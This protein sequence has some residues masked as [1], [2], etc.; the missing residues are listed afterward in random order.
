MARRFIWQ[1][2]NLEM[3]ELGRL[4]L[5]DA[6]W[7]IEEYHSE[8][9]QVTNVNL[10]Q[11]RKAN[12]Q[13][14]HI[15]LALRV[16]LVIKS[17]AFII[18]LYAECDTLKNLSWSYPT[19]PKYRFRDH[20]IAI[21]QIKLTSN[22]KLGV[23]MN[24][25]FLSFFNP[26]KVYTRNFQKSSTTNLEL[27]PLE[28]RIVPVNLSAFAV[29]AA[30]ENLENINALGSTV[31]F[32]N[33]AN[34]GQYGITVPFAHFT[35]ELRTAKGEFYKPNSNDPTLPFEIAPAI[36]VAAGSG[37]GPAV[38]I[39]DAQTGEIKRSFFA[40]DASFTGGVYLAAKDFNGDGIS[41]IITGAGAGGSAHIKIFDGT[42][43]QVLK[44]F[45]AFEPSFTGGVRV[46]AGD[47]N[48]DLI[49]EIIAAAGQGG[50]PHVKIFDGANNSLV[51]SWFAYEKD[52]T[53]GVYVAMGDLGHD[54]SPEVI[55]GAGI[56]GGPVVAIWNAST[57]G[58]IS[59]FFAYA[60]E[61]T[62]GVRVSTGD[63]DGNGVIDLITGAGIGGGPHIKVFSS[64]APTPAYEFFAGSHSATS[65]I[66][67]TV[68][69]ELIL[70][71]IPDIASYQSLLNLDY[72]TF[73]RSLIASVNDQNPNKQGFLSMVRGGLLDGLPADEVVPSNR[74]A[75][76]VRQ[77]RP[78]Q[79]E[80]DV[81][82]SLEF[83]L[84]NPNEI[85]NIDAALAGGTI[86]PSGPI[87]T[88]YDGTYL[89]EGH[90]RWSQTFL[91]NPAAS[92]LVYDFPNISDPFLALKVAQLGI[93]AERSSLDSASGGDPANNLLV[94]NRSTFDLDIDLMLDTQPNAKYSTPNTQ[95]QV[96]AVMA[97]FGNYNIGT[98]TDTPENRNA[99]K[100]Y[101]WKNVLV[102]QANNQP[103]TGTNAPD[104]I[105]MPQTTEGNQLYAPNFFFNL[106]SGLVNFKSP[107]SY[108]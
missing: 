13:R 106:A 104:R 9:K 67:P 21:V 28:Q 4:C 82:K 34:S 18:E 23:T 7:K 74:V 71:Q 3:D 44:S 87:I 42:T 12:A 25:W 91:L 59:R 10:C 108:Q 68:V 1:T 80:L 63:A 96:N 19:N 92:L 102:L 97:A 47:I 100:N 95:Q 41:E 79:N 99:L 2:I 27:F 29:G 70:P 103:I 38:A 81:F 40:Y 24:N 62:G 93:L 46:A 30:L 43:L 50:G 78:T 49:P 60:N 73:V 105:Y 33:P 32:F 36:L 57:G 90:H 88:G 75:F 45:I 37:G 8:L 15:G 72:V 14:V 69:P 31:G 16:I 17:G 83:P 107:V 66:F 55:T 5:S 11:F 76:G 94:M 65:G 89:V 98:G 22:F 61:F 84:R 101:L 56:G 35:G 58:L 53:G 77:L 48:G 64:S 6:F 51:A 26:F 86:T 85:Q 52:F 39:L 54:S 20:V